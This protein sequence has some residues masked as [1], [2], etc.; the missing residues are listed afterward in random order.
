ML[1]KLL[2]EQ[3]SK[4][5]DQLGPSI[6]AALPP[7][8]SADKESLNRILAAILSG[9]LDCWVNAREGEEGLILNAVAVTTFNVEPFS[10]TRELV[11]Y[12]VYALSGIGLKDWKEGYE[13]LRKY[14][15]SKGCLRLTAYTSNP[16]LVELANKFNADTQQTY[17]QFPVEL[18]TDKIYPQVSN[19]DIQ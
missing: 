12:A 2:P 14:A 9:R 3:V 6:E 7:N 11:V 16:K 18:A 4:F 13:V 5:W 10:L 1:V 19:E 8:V 17:I 15:M